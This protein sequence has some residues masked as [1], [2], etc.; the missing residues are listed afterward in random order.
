[1]PGYQEQVVAFIDVLGFSELVNASDTNQAAQA[2]I[3]K[4]IGTDEFYVSFMKYLYLTTLTF[5]SDSFVISMM[6][7]DRI[8]YMVREVGHL[9][10]HLLMLGL[11]CRGAITV[12]S[13]YHHKQIVVGP[14]FVNAHRLEQTV[15]IYP[16]VI[17]D[18][19]AMSYWKYEFRTDE[20]SGRSAHPHL[21][22]LVK[23]DNDGQH[24]IDIFNPNFGTDFMP[25][26]DIIP[27]PDVVPTDANEFLKEADKHIQAGIEANK[28]NLKVRAKYEWLA[29]ECRERAALL[30]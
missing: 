5:F 19:A 20:L 17:L 13:L 15:A 30:S 26:T 25:P 23:R 3:R 27:S 12:G 4:L 29:T 1:M 10:R 11:P 21:E 2:K 18:D 8:F 24:F 16:R 6:P 28:Y 9:C 22:N 14:A 7:P